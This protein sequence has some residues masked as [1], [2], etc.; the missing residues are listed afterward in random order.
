MKTAYYPNISEAAITPLQALALQFAEDPNIFESKDCPYSA[1]LKEGLRKLLVP[2]THPDGT[3]FSNDEIVVEITDLYKTL[4]NVTMSGDT[5]E[6]I[7]LM[8]T[9]ADLLTKMVALKEKAISIR[10]VASFQRAVLEILDSIITPQQ[11][12]EFVE[13]LGKYDV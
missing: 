13:R 5:R 2:V 1:T 6:Q 11:R 10:E 9:T 12:A 3:V 7:A 8:K 4:K